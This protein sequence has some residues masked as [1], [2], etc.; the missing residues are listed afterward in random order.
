MSAPVIGHAL[1]GRGPRHLLALH[2]WFGDHRSFDPLLPHFSEDDWSL[3]LMD[4]R[5][6]G[7]SGD[8]AGPYDVATIAADALALADH[9]GWDSFAVAGHSMGGKAALRVAAEAPG[10]VEALVGIAPVWAGAAPFDADA[11]AL[12]RSAA[13]DN[14]AREMIIRHST[15]D[16]LSDA[17]YAD[18][19]RDSER[20]ASIEAFAAYFESWALDDFTALADG[21]PVP[22]QVIVGRFDQ[23]ITAELV[24]ATWRRHLPSCDLLVL[25]NAGHYPMQE[26]PSAL[27]AAMI[28]FLSAGTSR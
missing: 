16:R 25:E 22:A 3:A 13:R 7:L 23:A 4:Q 5:G 9:L 28:G 12:F 6:Y 8:R 21:L 10:R 26:D 19:V 18:L 20:T 14:G 24:D 15:S 1:R 11:L 2:G 17:L 27:A